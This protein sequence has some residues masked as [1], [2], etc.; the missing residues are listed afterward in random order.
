MEVAEELVRRSSGLQRTR[1]L[2]AYHAQDAALCVEGM[3][4]AASAHAAEH[5]QGLVEI[6]R[7]VLN[8]KK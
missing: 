8:R 3:S 2:A 1:E 6:T 5:R 4:P 7:K